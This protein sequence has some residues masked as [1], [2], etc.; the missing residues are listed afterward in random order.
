MEAIEVIEHNGYRIEI[1]VDTDA[2]DMNPLTEDF[3][4]GVSG[5]VRSN[6]PMKNINGGIDWPMLT[7]EQINAN[8]KAI[9]DALEIGGLLDLPRA[10]R[11][12]FAVK[13]T[14]MTV[15]DMANELLEY[16][17]NGRRESEALELLVEVLRIAG[18]K[19]IKTNGN[20]Y[21]QGD[22]HE[23]V[24]AIDPKVEGEF[25]DPETALSGLADEYRKWR[26]GDVHGY[27]VKKPTKC[28]CCHHTTYETVDSCWGFISERDDESWKHM[29][30]QAKE[31]CE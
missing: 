30:E 28:K 23:I 7:T 16:A 13:P 27:I 3:A 8:S 24:L 18:I 21:V 26:Y 12:M 2:R 9:C 19:H 29:I 11:A 10:Y 25:G 15:A 1:H 22:W 5:I 31:N 14:N 17:Y 4:N 6:D 20:G